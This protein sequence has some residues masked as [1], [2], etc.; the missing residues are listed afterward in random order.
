LGSYGTYA[1]F[2]SSSSYAANYAWIRELRNNNTGMYREENT[3]TTKA[4]LHSV[5]CKKDATVPPVG[6]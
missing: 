5:R 3:T 2:W 4:Y 1:R 6:E